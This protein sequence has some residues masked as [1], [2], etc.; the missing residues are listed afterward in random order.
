LSITD[1]NEEEKKAIKLYLKRT[2]EDIV[3]SKYPKVNMKP[4][5]RQVYSFVK[6]L[7]T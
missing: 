7:N 1:L 2:T 5:E 6:N 3:D 4:I